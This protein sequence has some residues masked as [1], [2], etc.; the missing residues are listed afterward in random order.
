MKVGVA[1]FGE[2][3]KIEGIILEKKPGA[4]L[5]IKRTERKGRKKQSACGGGCLRP[6]SE[7]GRCSGVTSPLALAASPGLRA[8]PFF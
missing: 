3:S 4:S 5:R 7:V 2:T 1:Q 8:S 6:N